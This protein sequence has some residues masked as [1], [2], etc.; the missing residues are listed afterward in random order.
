MIMC[1]HTIAVRACIYPADE[2]R[3]FR[4]VDAHVYRLAHAARNRRV[5]SFEEATER[6]IMEK[7][8]TRARHYIN[9]R[10]A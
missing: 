7:F 1:A 5:F 8:E 3:Y 9:T 6:G 4:K 2:T 10:G